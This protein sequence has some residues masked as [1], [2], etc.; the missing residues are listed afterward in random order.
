MQTPGFQRARSAEHKRQRRDEMLDAA[1]NLALDKGVRAVT[2]TDIAAEIGVHKSAVLRYF[3]TREA[4]FLELLTEGWAEWVDACVPAVEAAGSDPVE[5]ARAIAETLSKR[6]L[7]CDLLA[8]APMNLERGVSVEAVREFKLTSF[9]HIDRFVQAVTTALPTLTKDEGWSLISAVNAL[10]ST[11]WQI[12][13][14]TAAVAEL[15]RTDPQIGHAVGD[16][17]PNLR[18]QTETFILGLLARRGI[19]ARP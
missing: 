14:P 3:E 19:G 5:V 6:P 12:T 11:L 16:F 1:R 8:H 15:Y 9:G 7:F 18:E 13:H 10:A 17:G 2:M 4:V